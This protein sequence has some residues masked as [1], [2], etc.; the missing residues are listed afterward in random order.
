VSA[1]GRALRAVLCGASVARTSVRCA[2]VRA[3]AHVGGEPGAQRS[4][5]PPPPP[6]QPQPPR[7]RHTSHHVV[8]TNL[9]QGAQERQP[10]RRRRGPAHAHG[11]GH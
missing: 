10:A 5:R 9:T 2:R 1:G 4:P 11:Q 7:T 8:M 6:P 3:A